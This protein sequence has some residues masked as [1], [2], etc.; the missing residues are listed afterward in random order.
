MTR[1][2][3]D[4]W[5]ITE[6]VGATALGVAAGRAAETAS[7]QPLISD[8]YAQMF[9]DEAGDGFPNFYGR[10]RDLPPELV[11]L[12]PRI[13]ERMQ[14]MKGY[15]ASRTLFFDAFFM[16][17]AAAG[18]RQAVILA[19]GLDARAWRLDWPAGCV[20]YELD[21]PKVLDF[22][23]AT[24]ASHG[25]SPATRYVGV[26]VDLRHDWPA[27]LSSSGFDPALPT[28]W[29]AEGLLPYLTSDAQDVLFERLANS[30]A[31]GS[32]VAVE[33]FT[34]EFFSAE[35]VA[36]REE[37]MKRY[38]EA[39]AKVGRGDLPEVGNLVYEEKRTKVVDWLRARG[40]SAD[41]VDASDLMASNGRPVPSDLED[42]TPQ[43]VFVEGRLPA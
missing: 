20:V 17:A 22:K 25:V 12:D 5:D 36:R 31:P 10:E 3:D 28:A 23:T 19:A 37:Q 26:P 43:S 9:L 14:A 2:E 11:E 41:G 4:T 27:A 24:L 40:W 39:A 6:S 13:G 29:S 7:D 21:Q 15:I 16:N 18:V 33:D 35:S 30:S 1:T 34:H 32:R 42:A 8:P 38:R